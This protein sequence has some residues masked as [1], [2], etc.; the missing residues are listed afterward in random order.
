M[1]FLSAEILV[2][3]TSLPGLQEEGRFLIPF[4]NSIV[5]MGCLEM[6]SHASY[7]ATAG[8]LSVG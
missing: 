3:L 4:C 1:D 6:V 7:E 8:T 5:W 2:L